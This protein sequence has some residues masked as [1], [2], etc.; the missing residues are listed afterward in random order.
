[1]SDTANDRASLRLG[2]LL[3]PTAARTQP[4][5]SLGTTVKRDLGRYYDTLAR[6]LATVAQL[7]TPGEALT[8]CDL[9]SSTNWETINN[10]ALWAQV[11]DADQ[12]QLDEWAVDRDQIVSKL[13]A[14]TPSQT[15]AVIDALERWWLLP[16]DEAT[17]HETSLAAVGLQ[18]APRRMDTRRA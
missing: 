15:A 13:R 12:A 7:L 5:D 14:L 1:M 18:P 8:L 16:D 4:G 3:K 17:D 6:E 11:A 9:N 10:T 2:G